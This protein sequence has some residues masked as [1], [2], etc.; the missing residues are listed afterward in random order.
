MHKLI[1]SRHDGAIEWLREEL[2][3]FAE[4]EI[5]ESV[6][7]EQVK[8]ADVVGNLPLFLASLCAEF[9]AIEFAGAPPRGAEYGA[10]E[11]RQAGARLVAYKV[12]R[13]S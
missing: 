11:M 1:V 5:V 9:R 7:P 12:T 10:Q 6:T 2:T 8:G 4:R 13:L 3:D